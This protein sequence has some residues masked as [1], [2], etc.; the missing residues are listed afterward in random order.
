MGFIFAIPAATNSGVV[1]RGNKEYA[2]ITIWLFHP[3][4]LNILPKNCTSS[5]FDGLKN[6]PAMK[7]IYK[8]R[9]NRPNIDPITPIQMTIQMFRPNIICKKTMIVNAGG[10]GKGTASNIKAPIN[11]NKYCHHIF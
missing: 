5:F 10:K 9:T 4:S 11:N 3:F 8:V 2:I 6:L 7:G 1:G